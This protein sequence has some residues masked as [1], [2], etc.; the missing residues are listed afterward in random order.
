M[1]RHIM[2]LRTS[3]HF[4]SVI[5]LQNPDNRNFYPLLFNEPVIKPFQPDGT[6]RKSRLFSWKILSSFFRA[7]KAR[8]MPTLWAIFDKLVPRYV[9][10]PSEKTPPEI[11]EGKE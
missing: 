3:N 6:I 1:V 4:A 2:I 7:F 11:V 5:K 8:I 10:N 9:S